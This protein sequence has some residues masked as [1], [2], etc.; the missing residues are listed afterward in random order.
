[1]AAKDKKQAKFFITPA[2]HET[3]RKYADI[4]GK[5]MSVVVEELIEEVLEL[6]LKELAPELPLEG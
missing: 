5:S 2:A 3:L 4:K 1:M 6:E